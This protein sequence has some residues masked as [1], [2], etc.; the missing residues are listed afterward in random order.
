M[1]TKSTDYGFAH[2]RRGETEGNEGLESFK[3]NVEAGIR[4]VAD[5]YVRGTGGEDERNRLLYYLKIENSSF[6]RPLN[7]ILTG[8]ALG[9][10][11]EELELLASAVQLSQ[12]FILMADDFID[13]AS[14]RRGKPSY[15][16]MY[17]KDNTMNDAL[18]LLS[19]TWNMISDYVN[20]R[21]EALGSEDAEAIRAKFY[22]IGALT[23][24]GESK[25][26][27][28]LKKAGSLA[29]ISY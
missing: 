3:K 7:L 6:R 9:A 23:Y 13:D 8:M 17:G 24:Y 2:L 18:M 22:E 16:A 26:I 11:K 19:L 14:L 12:E 25:D 10:K 15:I 29:R 21:K 4:R 20:Y 28:M 5:R 1:P 27:N